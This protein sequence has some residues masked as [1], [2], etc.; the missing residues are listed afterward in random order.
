MQNINVTFPKGLYHSIYLKDSIFEKR[1]I[2]KIDKITDAGLNIENC[3]FN[4]GYASFI[5]FSYYTLL[6]KKFKVFLMKLCL[7]I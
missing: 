7:H 1:T 5:P 2:F 6:F 4:N 3:I